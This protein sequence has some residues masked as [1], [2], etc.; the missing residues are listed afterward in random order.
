MIRIRNLCKEWKEFSLNDINLEIKKGEYFIILGPTGAGKT[1]LLETIAGFHYP[2]SGKIY[3]DDKDVSFLPPEKRKV[4]FVYQEFMLFPHK[5]V[6][7]N[8]AFGLKIRGEKNIREQVEEMAKLV[9]IKNILYRY[10]KK[11]SGGEKQRVSIARALIIKPKIL[12]MDEPLSALDVFTQKKLRNEL[13]RIHNETGVTILHVTHDQEEAL[14]LGDRIG[15]MNNGEIIQVGTPEEVFRKPRTEFVAN[16][17]GVE[18]LFSGN[19]EIKKNIT[20]IKI[21]NVVLHSTV[22]KSG[23][24]NVSTRPEDIIV[25]KEKMRSSARNVLSGKITG[26]EDRGAIIKLNVECG[27]SL[28]VIITRES[29]FDLK[30]KIGSKIYLYFK[31]GNVHLF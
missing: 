24:V 23:R 8:I 10:P 7:E 30:L 15:I 25:S 11:L 29:F 19:A 1:L 17:V 16:F 20:E 22:K 28:V 9:G 3:I 21:D 14:V 2:D 13:K 27:I 26:I 6:F 5:N 4:G 12:L 18:N 31:A